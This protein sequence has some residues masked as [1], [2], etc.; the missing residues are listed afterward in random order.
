MISVWT[1]L[2]KL[3]TQGGAAAEGARAVLRTR[4]GLLSLRSFCAVFGVL[5]FLAGTETELGT[6]TPGVVIV[7]SILLL[8]GELLGRYLF[9]ASH[10]RVG[11]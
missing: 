9:Y 5:L 6:Q 7:A 4:R 3:E 11:L 8:L 2:T 1:H 10:R